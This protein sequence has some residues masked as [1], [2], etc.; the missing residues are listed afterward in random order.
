MGEASDVIHSQ[1]IGIDHPESAA[2]K[3][4]SIILLARMNMRP[5]GSHSSSSSQSWS[6]RNGNRSS[7]L[8]KQIQTRSARVTESECNLGNWFS[9]VFRTVAD[10]TSFAR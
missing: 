2:Q 8:Q 1:S 6:L 9:I 7:S 10:S 3:C 5:S 4:A